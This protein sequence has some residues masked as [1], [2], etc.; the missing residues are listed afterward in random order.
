MAS[1]HTVANNRTFR[2]AVDIDQGKDRA[3]RARATQWWEHVPPVACYVR[4][5]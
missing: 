1:G 2:D 4:S 3:P 5:S